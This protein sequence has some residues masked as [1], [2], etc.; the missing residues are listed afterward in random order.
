MN[1]KLNLYFLPLGNPQQVHRGSG[2]LRRHVE[3]DQRGSKT[4]SIEEKQREQEKESG[5]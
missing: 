5:K 4:T 3:K 1:I 2:K